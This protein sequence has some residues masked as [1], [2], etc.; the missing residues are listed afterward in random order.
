M[1]RKRKITGWKWWIWWVLW[2]VRLKRKMWQVIDGDVAV[3]TS[4]RGRRALDNEYLAQSDLGIVR[5]RRMF[6][7]ALEKPSR[8]ATCRTRDGGS[9]ND[10]VVSWPL[11][12]AQEARPP[13]KDFT[14]GA[15]QSPTRYWRSIPWEEI[16]D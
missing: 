6:I 8:L 1:V 10:P 2:Q 11:F 7:E 9:D 13:L 16:P 15:R 3:L 14:R 5:M 4:Q 12:T